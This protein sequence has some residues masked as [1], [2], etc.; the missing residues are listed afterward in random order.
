[1]HRVSVLLQHVSAC[2]R[3]Q[4]VLDCVIIGAGAAGLGAARLLA[5]GGVR[6]MVVLEARNRIGG[7]VCTLA[8]PDPTLPSA[9]G[10]LPSASAAVAQSA[11]VLIER[12]AEFIHGQHSSVRALASELGHEVVEVPRKQLLSWAPRPGLAAQSVLELPDAEQRRIQRV[13]DHYNALEHCLLPHDMSLASYFR[14]AGFDEDDVRAADVIFAQTCNMSAEELSCHYLQHE[15]RTDAGEREFRIVGGYSQLLGRL[16]ASLPIRL[17]T[18]VT[19]VEHCAVTGIVKV[20]AADGAVFCAR[21][22][23]V[24][25]PLGVL[26]SRAVRFTPDLPASRWALI[27]AIRMHAA[28]KLVYRFSRPHWSRELCYVCAP[29]N[30]FGR[31]W[32]PGFGQPAASQNFICCYVTADRAAHVDAMSERDACI[33]GLRALAELLAV[34]LALLEADLVAAYRMSWAN[35]PYTRGGYAAPV[36]SAT[37]RTA[38]VELATAVCGGCV[39]FAGEHTAYEARSTPQTVHGALDSGRRAAREAMQ[40]LRGARVATDDA[41]V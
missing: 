12:G 7:R 22:C 28:T 13:R 19:H 16:A 24:T 11:P 10:A 15:F 33:A 23:I 4:P 3:D 38:H 25:L 29:G 27:D 36:A 8:L 26:Q 5:D 40:S 6:N 35:E 9:L 32:T 41:R 18:A 14:A 37:A 2:E 21:T 34:S 30:A 39:L 31:W 17:S 20:T 1:M